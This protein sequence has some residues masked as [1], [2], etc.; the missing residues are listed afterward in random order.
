MNAR[1]PNHR[2]P[3]G[4]THGAPLGGDKGRTVGNIAFR[5]RSGG[6]VWVGKSKGASTI[7]GCDPVTIPASAGDGATG[8][9]Y[10]DR[11]R[12]SSSRF[13]FRAVYITIGQAV[14]QILGRRLDLTCV[15][16]PSQVP[17][18]EPGVDE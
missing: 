4:G 17:P 3:V 2:S 10:N 6:R 9:Q 13:V 14:R 11:Q 16:H 15:R 8:G 5:P 18:P 1:T 12:A 7:G